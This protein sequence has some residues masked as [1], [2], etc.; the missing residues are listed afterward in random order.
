[1]TLTKPHNALFGDL[2]D[3][4]FLCIEQIWQLKYTIHVISELKYI[5]HF[6]YELRQCLQPTLGMAKD[7]KT[8]V[9]ILRKGLDTLKQQ[10]QTRKASLEARLRKKETLSDAD[11][12]IGRAHV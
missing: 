11:K 10:V 12:Q 1:M 6:V 9:T 5:I 8:P 2:L 3:F 4:K 7:S